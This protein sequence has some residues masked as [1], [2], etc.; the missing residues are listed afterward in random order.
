MYFVLC[1]VVG[2]ALFTLWLW[3]GE[4][5]VSGILARR[6]HAREAQERAQRREKAWATKD[7]RAA[8][9]LAEWRASRAKVDA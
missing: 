5:R 8:T 3:L 6:R 9:S 1:V 2:P 4:S 7:D